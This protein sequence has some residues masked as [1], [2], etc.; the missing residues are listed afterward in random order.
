MK[1]FKVMV[2][3]K[4]Y[5]EGCISIGYTMREDSLYCMEEVSKDGE[6]THKHTRPAWL[7][8]DDEFVDEIPLSKS[9]DINLTTIQFG[10]ARNWILSKHVDIEDWKR[11]YDAYANSRKS[12]G[13]KNRSSHPPSK[14][15]VLWLW[16]E[17]PLFKARSYKKY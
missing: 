6:G 14:S 8:D 13:Q 15:F 3:N 10:Q 1:D 5:I 4:R 2:R 16:D 11:K 12:R 7:D 9:K 17:G